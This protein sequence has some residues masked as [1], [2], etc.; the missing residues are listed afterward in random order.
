MKSLVTLI[1]VVLTLLFLKSNFY[2]HERSLLF[3]D[4]S[5]EN[6]PTNQKLVQTPFGLADPSRIHYIDNN[7]YIH[8]DDDS[9]HIINKS[10]G[11]ITRTHPIAIEE[12][13]GDSRD[14]SIK[15]DLNPQNGWITYA[16]G[17]L[18]YTA[19][20]ISLF[21]TDFQ[22]PSPPKTET[23]QLIYIF[24]GLGG[25]DT[26]SHIIQPVL[27]WGK[28]PS[29]GGGYWAICNW[30]VT[31]DLHYFYDSL[32]R[33][34]PGS[35]LTA[36]VVK[37]AEENNRFSY[38]SS[39]AGY[40]EGLTIKNLPKLETL[41]ITFEGYNIKGC[42][43]Y[44]GDEKVRFTNIQIRSDNEYSEANW[45]TFEEGNQPVALCGQFTSIVNK[46]PSDGEI[47]IHFHAPTPIKGSEDIHLYP[48]PVT[49]LL[50]ISPVFRILNCHIDI[51]N[52]NGQIVYSNF[53]PI[54]DYEFDIDTE[55]FPSGIYYIRFKY[56]HETNPIN[57][58]IQFSQFIKI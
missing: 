34:S 58:A 9:I 2:E 29:G 43:E 38:N 50:H 47:H 3:I 46:S 26:I 35:R 12:E 8:F 55:D 52:S 40:G 41:Y 39:F 23:N 45:Y 27:Q 1:F 48:N 31:G 10:S 6:P 33:V 24:S 13:K 19:T 37:I 21:S 25:F 56:H 30:Y 17:H 57:E 54:L 53:K 5:S 22:V 44:P 18:A 20:P 15:G 7:Q 42:Y 16:Y 51:L 32:I 49:N 28:S 14:S 4:N 36:R 11:T